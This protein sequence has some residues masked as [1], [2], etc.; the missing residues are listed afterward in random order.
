MYHEL[1]PSALII[2]AVFTLYHAVKFRKVWKQ[3][4]ENTSTTEQRLYER[5]H[6]V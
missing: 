2:I 3:W 5:C 4:Y 1:F 6:G